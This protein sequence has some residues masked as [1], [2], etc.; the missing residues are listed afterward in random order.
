M[1][2]ELYA[3]Y[4]RLSGMYA[5]PTAQVNEACAKRWFYEV[6]SKDP[7]GQDYE[8]YAVGEYDSVT[9]LITAYNKTKFITRYTDEV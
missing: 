8:L 1:K 7:H 9:G 3:I 2:Y 4:D 6:I 5:A